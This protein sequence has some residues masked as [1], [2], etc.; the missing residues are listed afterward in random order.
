L[1]VARFYAALAVFLF[2]A[3]LVGFYSIDTEKV[4]TARN[5]LQNFGNFGVTF[6]FVLS[7]FVLT[8]SRRPGETYLSFV[9]RRAIR[10]FPTHWATYLIAIAL[11]GVGSVNFGTLVA[12]AFLLHSWVPRADTYF[13]VNFPS[14]SI[15]TEIFF[16]A[17]FPLAILLL[18]RL[19]R[20]GL[21][22]TL[23]SSALLATL[24]PFITLLEPFRSWPAFGSDFSVTPVYG[25]SQLTVW[26]LYT[27][28]AARVVDFVAGICIAHLVISSQLPRIK[29]GAALLGLGA[30]YVVSLHAPLEWQ[31]DSLP[32]LAAIPLVASLAQADLRQASMGGN[33]NSPKKHRLGIALGKVSFAFYLLHEIILRY[34]GNEIEGTSLTFLTGVFLTGGVFAV[35]LMGAWFLHRFIEEPP[36]RATKRIMVAPRS[37]EQVSRS[38]RSGARLTPSGSDVAASQSSPLAV[39]YCWILLHSLLLYTVGQHLT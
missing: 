34:V 35:S 37:P 11:V 27:F 23:A 36:I 20:I 22:V 38:K 5:M 31:L 21:Y 28:P 32:L 39:A 15:S 14:W 13:S 24:L 26:F 7:G 8:W 18:G 4:D 3:S 19:R 33:K 2:H 6:F 17:I 16:Y 30:W 12:N 1:T 9:T 10:L 29:F 25:E